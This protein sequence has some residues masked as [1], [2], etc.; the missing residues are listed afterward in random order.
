[1]EIIFFLDF[2]SN[3][4]L[5]FTVLIGDERINKH[6]ELQFALGNWFLN[7]VIESLIEKFPKVTSDLKEHDTVGTL[8]TYQIKISRFCEYII[9]IHVS[10]YTR[11]CAIGKEIKIKHF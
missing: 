11:K 10:S 1:M 9:R 8:S 2:V 6:L 5:F 4:K 3:F 7:N